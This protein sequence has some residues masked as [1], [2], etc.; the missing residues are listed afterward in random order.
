MT[1]AKRRHGERLAK[2][3]RAGWLEHA[4]GFG[5]LEDGMGMR[6]TTIGPDKFGENVASSWEPVL[7]DSGK[8]IGELREL[9]SL[10]DGVLRIQAA[11]RGGDAQRQE[12]HRCRR[13]IAAPSHDEGAALRIDR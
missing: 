7:D 11:R 9:P 12:R 8:K 6:H 1:K 5:P 13:P 10:Y 2:T 4:S 3:A